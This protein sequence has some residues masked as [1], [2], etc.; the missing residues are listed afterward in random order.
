[1]SKALGPRTTA[2]LRF[3]CRLGTLVSFQLAAMFGGLVVASLLLLCLVMTLLAIEQL[4][5]AS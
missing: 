4:W 5:P 1:M 3:G 2:G